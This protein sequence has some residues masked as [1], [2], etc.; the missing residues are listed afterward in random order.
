MQ[1]GPPLSRAT[2]DA[3]KAVLVRVAELLS[4]ELFSPLLNGVP[5]HHTLFSYGNKNCR[6]NEI[7]SHNLEL[8]KQ[9]IAKFTEE[10]V[11]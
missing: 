6:T 11:G 3:L 4:P 2:P 7:A 1:N 8:T 5:C 10:R 9:P